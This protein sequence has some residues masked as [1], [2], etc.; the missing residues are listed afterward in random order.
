MAFAVIGGNCDDHVKNFSFLM[1][2]EGEWKLSPAYD[3]TF[4]YNPGNR[5]ISKHQMSING[6]TSG[7]TSDDLIASGKSMGLTVEFCRNAISQTESVVSD[8]LSYAEKCGITEER[9]VEIHRG[10]RL[11]DNRNDGSL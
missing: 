5:W 7:I 4:A 9:A 8:W 2:R 1:N 6:K 11:S 3:L 10:I